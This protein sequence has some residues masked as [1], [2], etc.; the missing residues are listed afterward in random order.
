MKKRLLNV[1]LS[2]LA[3]LG[4][5]L[6]SNLLANERVGDFALLDHQGLFHHIAWYDNR[7]AVVLLVHTN[8]SGAA[9]DA[10]PAFQALKN[11]HGD[12]FQFFLLNPLGESRN[13]VAAAA[14][15]Q[16]HDIP[17]LIDDAQLIAEAMEV[18]AAGEVLV[19]DPRTFSLV[20]RGPVSGL[21][22]ALADIDAGSPVSS[23][24]L[25]V[26]GETI[27]YPARDNNM[28]R[29]ISYSNEV[30]PILAEN[31]ASCH[32]E[33]GI[34]PFALNSH[35]MA[36]GWSPMIRE[37]LMTKRMPPGQID[38]HVGDFENSYTVSVEDQQTILHWIA[39]GSQ[40]DGPQDP[41]ADL[42]WPAS[43]W[44]F[45]EPDLIVKVPPQSIPATGVLDYRNVV[46]P[47]EGLTE[48]RWV[49]ASQYIAGDH[50]VL[51][52]TL[53]S[54]LPPGSD[55]RR[56]FLGGSNP[57]EP[58]I[59]AYIPG[60]EPYH[61]PENTGGLLRAGSQLALQLHYTTTGRETVD[62][63]EIGIWFYPEGYVPGKRM[64]GQCA[65]IF[66][67][68][69]TNIPPN[70]PDFEMAQTITV[71]RDA[72]LHSFL[73]HMHFR[74]KRMRFEAQYPDGSSEELINIANYNYNW[75]LRY[76]LS[77]PKLVPAG[78]K[79]VATGAFDNSS[80]NKANPDPDR[81]VPWGLQSWDEMFFG[82]VS[83]QYVDPEPATEQ[84][85]VQ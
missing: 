64:S 39:Q 58:S 53:N 52:H 74:G 22:Q 15:A 31:C 76:Q 81:S 72:Y 41:L 35:N 61:E 7:K 46:V 18:R 85:A 70:D 16:G 71:P 36:Q 37:V 27:S 66:T 26:A 4:M 40:F 56:N 29:T 62:A 19:L 49:R 32:R 28:A 83:W 51:H 5:T 6:G 68:T 69:W 67:P 9:E 79:I 48:D 42:S 2:A 12:D 44:A 78:T 33:G 17:V 38:P 65:C 1:S 34:A 57:D 45:G 43:E 14:A 63:S 82:A 21:E 73:P 54:I 3:V 11:V 8:S 25:A 60:A 47:F 23:P 50:T 84:V 80:Q 24:E 20:Y 59:T 75:Q 10:L 77:E 55:G 13:S 30:A